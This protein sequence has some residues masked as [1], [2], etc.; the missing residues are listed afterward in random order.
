MYL[1][2]MTLAFTLLLMSNTAS[3]QEL[4]IQLAN[5]SARFMYITEAFGQDFG[6]VE[7][8]S[9]FLYNKNNDYLLNM[10]LLVRGESVSVP[11]IVSIGARAYYATVSTATASY[12]VSA[13]A[14]GG[15]LL[16]TPDSWGGLGLGAY[17]YT[18]PGVV[19][20]SDAKGL[21]EYGVYASYQ[22]TPQANISVGFQ[23]IDTNINNVGD[24]TIDK[25]TYFA[26]NLSF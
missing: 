1:R 3:S 19:S 22:I 17:F 21:S 4:R 6:R 12:T 26:L 20:F 25:G 18:A 13:I 2:I 16:L 14:I 11:V 5:D 23:N 7:L 9:G 24:V 8:E 15:D 10:G